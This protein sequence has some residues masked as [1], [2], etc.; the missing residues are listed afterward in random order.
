MSSQKFSL[1][2]YEDLYWIRP[3]LYMR[4]FKYIHGVILEI[5]VYYYI[6]SFG[7]FILNLFGIFVLI[8]NFHNK[9]LKFEP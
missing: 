5:Q 2:L 6:I 1:S 8:I 4:K 9:T 7:L 3:W